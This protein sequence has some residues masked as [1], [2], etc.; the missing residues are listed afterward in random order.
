M[1]SPVENIFAT[2]IY[3]RNYPST[4]SLNKDLLQ[5]ALSLEEQQQSSDVGRAH[6]GGFYTD[7]TLFEQK[8]PGIN[9]VRNLFTDSL[10]EYIDEMGASKNVKSIQLQGWL[11]LTRGGDYQT[12]HIHRGASISGV[13]YVEVPDEKKAPDPEGCIDFLTP[14]TEQEMTF[15]AG[16]SKSH[17]RI[18]PHP[19]SLTLFPSY[20]R[21]F[22]H[23][24]KKSAIRLC[25]V[26]NA[27]VR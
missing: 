1:P 11:A 25:V 13:Y 27:F 12:P 16:I 10:R 20:L 24:L 2:P 14:V 4:D 19:G 23:P 7:G 15:L 22:T 26:C 6:Q 18:R 8:L 3:F 17:C 9:R 21:H 5:T